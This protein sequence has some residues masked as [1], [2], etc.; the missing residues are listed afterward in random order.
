MNGAPLPG[1]TI[2]IIGGQLGRMLVMAATTGLPTWC[3]SLRPCPAE[4]VANRHLV[5]A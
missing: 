1:A 3:W 5:A 4:Q 2:G